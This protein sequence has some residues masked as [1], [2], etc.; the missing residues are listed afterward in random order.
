LIQFFDQERKKI[1]TKEVKAQNRF[2]L[3]SGPVCNHVRKGPVP[4]SNRV[5]FRK[6]GL[7]T[8]LAQTQDTGSE[9]KD[10]NEF[11]QLKF[12]NT[13]T[14]LVVIYRLMFLDIYKLFFQ[15]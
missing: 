8:A 15:F 2:S 14:I 12:F 11:P 3:E 1:S 5:H 10:E 6:S 7:S 9:Y 13:Y 4:R